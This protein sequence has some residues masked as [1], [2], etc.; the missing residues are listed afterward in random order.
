[1]GQTTC[2][3]IVDGDT[4]EDIISFDYQSDILA[5]A[6]E[7]HFVVAGSKKWRDKLKIGASVQFL[8]QNAA[9]NGGVATVR[10][11]GRLLHRESDVTPGEGWTIS[12]TSFDLG[13]HLVNSSAPIWVGL[14]GKTFADLVDPTTSPLF[15]P[16][17]GFQTPTLF[18]GD[19]RRRLKM[20]LALVAVSAQRVLDPAHRIQTEPADVA[21]DK[22]VEYATRINLCC[23]VSP[24]GQLC[25]YRPNDTAA[26][27]YALRLRDGDE[28]NNL[29]RARVVEDAKE[30]Y[31]QCEVVGDPVGWDGPVDASSPNSQRK[32][33]K[34]SHPG[35][36]P[37][38]HALA[39]VEPQAFQNG[40]AQKFAEWDYKR[41]MWNS[42]YY[43]ASVLEHH[44]NGY[45]LDC[46]NVASV[47]D[48]VNDLHGNLYVAAVRCSGNKTDGD[49]SSLIL[50][51]PGLLSATIEGGVPNP[52]IY[53]A[54]SVKGKPKAAP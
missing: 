34:V 43:E 35:A 10:H 36:L 2:R 5:V 6:E 42:F 26:P 50:R 51:M 52:P 47:E 32:R 46:D 27:L 24:S 28:R 44:Q 4:C 25:C 12:C 7:A 19:I 11:R 16:S 49:V 53:G 9:V 38:K 20:G 13:W 15:D 17:W 41:G 8:M 39:R 1:M 54:N 45:W 37:F 30:R 22:I 31:T 40:L 21:W 29:L 14:E 33:G 48:D 18:D 3:V 23:N